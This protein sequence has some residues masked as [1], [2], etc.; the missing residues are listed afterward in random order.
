MMAC[1]DSYF[2][3][4]NSKGSLILLQAI[5][6][7]GWNAEKKCGSNCDQA[8]PS[9]NSIQILI[10]YAETITERILYQAITRSLRLF[11]GWNQ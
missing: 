2:P 7:Q 8:N 1:A 4:H 6:Y 10:W 5:R 3:G 9:L 11:S